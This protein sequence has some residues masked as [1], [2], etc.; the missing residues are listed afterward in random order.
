MR[1]DK[2]KYIVEVN[3]PTVEM[4]LGLW[5]SGDSFSL[6][7]Q[8]IFSFFPSLLL[9][10]QSFSV[11]TWLKKMPVASLLS[12]N[13]QSAIS[14]Q[15]S[16]ITGPNQLQQYANYSTTNPPALLCENLEAQRELRPCTETQSVH[17]A[18]W[19]PTVPYSPDLLK[20]RR[21]AWGCRMNWNR[22]FCTALQIIA[23][24]FLCIILSGFPCNYFPITPFNLD[25][26]PL[27]S[28]HNFQHFPIIAR[29]E[30]AVFGSRLWGSDAGGRCNP[31]FLLLWLG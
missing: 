26:G 17:T 5:W 29:Y 11:Q 23:H 15:Q 10:P 31:A 12:S 4:A 8:C 9:L 18:V 16:T 27:A 2:V 28:G 20:M 21:R 22:K 6:C 25:S 13:R 30:L 3:H 7:L 1:V 24:F 19:P 14:N